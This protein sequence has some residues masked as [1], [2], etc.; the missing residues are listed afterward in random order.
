MFI[1][2]EMKTSPANNILEAPE[3]ESMDSEDLVSTIQ[4]SYYSPSY[5]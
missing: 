4:V 2:A 5:H 1:A 3:L